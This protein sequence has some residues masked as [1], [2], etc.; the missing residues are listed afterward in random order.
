MLAKLEKGCTHTCIVHP[1]SHQSARA[2]TRWWCCSY[3]GGSLAPTEVNI[4]VVANRQEAIFPPRSDWIANYRPT[5]VSASLTITLAYSRF[6]HLPNYP[7]SMLA[8]WGQ[9]LS[10]TP[11]PLLLACSMAKNGDQNV[12][13]KQP[14]AQMHGRM[15]RRT[16]VSLG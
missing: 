15:D 13:V 7:S 10:V 4:A 1:A 8:A 3:S 2:K 16:N 9:A 12:E 14:S 6:A 5:Y 11:S